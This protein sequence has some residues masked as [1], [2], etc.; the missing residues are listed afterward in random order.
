MSPATETPGLIDGLRRDV[1]RNLFRAR[2]GIK[3]ATGLSRPQTGLTPKEVVW[4]RG[5]AV[6]FRYES[7]RRTRRTPVLIVF[8]VLGRSYVL[9][10]RPDSSFIAHLLNAG[11]D[12][13]M[14]DF[15]VP[16]GVDATNTL[17]TYVD[18]YLPAAAKAAMEESGSDGV[19]VVGY[20][21]GGVL[22]TLL[23]AGHPEIP[24]NSLTL[25]ATPFDFSHSEGAIQALMRGK[26]EIDDLVD[27]T[28]NVPASV[29]HRM[30]RTL[31]PTAGIS[32]YAMLWERLWSD[33]FVDAFQAM[34]MWAAD[35]V[36]FPGDLARQCLDLL[37]RRNLLMTG[38]VP[39]RRHKV[40]LADITCPL[41]TIYA[42]GDHIVSPRS[43]LPI[44]DLVSSK[45]IT[46]LAIPAGHIGLAVSRHAYKTT[47]PGLVTWLNA[48]GS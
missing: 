29:V 30:F 11:L 1:E 26:L 46:T 16:D 9:D 18:R 39:L 22:A 15:G 34:S 17:E 25:M 20:C 44:N 21:F 2:N 43:S 19:D 12:V 48:Q 47:I 14:V 35:Q 23:V 37:L 8:S 33:E 6:M 40:R 38:L 5:K 31:K 32:T 45:D 13:Y 42:E 3:Y 41:L 7:E 27:D 4:S 36:P 28:G 24:F 10:L